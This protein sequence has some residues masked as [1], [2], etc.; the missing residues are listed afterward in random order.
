MTVSML[1]INTV[2]SCERW[3][4]HLSIPVAKERLASPI[5]GS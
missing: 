4:R 1:L 5:A 3:L 2:T